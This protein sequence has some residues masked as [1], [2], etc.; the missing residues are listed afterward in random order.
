LPQAGDEAPPADEMT[1]HQ[2]VST[3]SHIA[4]EVCRTR[5][6]QE[7]EEREAQDLLTEGLQRGTIII[8]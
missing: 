6:Q 5:A 7:R 8:R 4:R 1:C 3:G 2:E